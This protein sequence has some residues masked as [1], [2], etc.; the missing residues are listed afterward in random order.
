MCLPFGFVYEVYVFVYFPIGNVYGTNT[1]IYLPFGNV[2]DAN[3]IA[4]FPLDFMCEGNAFIHLPSCPMH[5]W[6]KKDSF[7]N[8]KSIWEL[9]FVCRFVR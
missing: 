4:Y 8:I 7:L 5:F 6:L 9:N 1:F 3:A 2:Y